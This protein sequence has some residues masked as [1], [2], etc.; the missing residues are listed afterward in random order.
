MAGLITDEMLMHFTVDCSWDEL[1][2]TL[3]AKYDGIADRLVCYFAEEMA[4]QDPD[5][6]AKLGEV[7]AALR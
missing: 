3:A 7:A 5:A 6:L 1:A 4:H 2:D